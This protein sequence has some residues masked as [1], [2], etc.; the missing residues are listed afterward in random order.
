M[1]MPD[2]PSEPASSPWWQPHVH[3]DR[4]ALLL[5]RNAIKAGLRGWFEVEGF[6][7]VDTAC[8]QVS[9]GN[10]THIHAFAT[11]ILAPTGARDLA[12]LHTSPEFA[13]KKLLA[14]GETQIFT[15]APVF[16]NRDR[17]RLHAPEFMML[18][19]YRAGA[20]FAD[21]LIDCDA[22]IER[23]AAV[24]GVGQFR[25]RGVVCNAEPAERL[26]VCEAFQRDAGIDL[27]AH[28]E[29]GAT[30]DAFT[31]LANAR[32]IRTA[33]DDTW[34][35]IFARVLTEKIEPKL[36]H[37]RP[38]LLTHYPAQEAALARLAPDDP[39]VAERVE[40]YICGV[41]VANGFAELTDADEQRRRFEMAMAERARIY[42]DRYPIDESFLAAL[43]LMPE[44]V[45]CA[46]GFDRLVM[47]TLG[48]PNVASVMWTPVAEFPDPAPSA[49]K[50]T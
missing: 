7:E 14:A 38:T 13:C 44:A 49:G 47:L 10:E 12:Y 17:G 43:E 34:S 11:E 9:P 19:W 45:G 5:A 18:E 26:T 30:R 50:P 33:D 40:L 22:L 35:D 37:P 2:R 32:G 16:R 4:R 27:R 41:E 6:T 36:G 31:E 23:A 28:L 8:L 1:R 29:A 39:N 48:A 15:F 46:L 3:A 21:L 24:A 20:S 25:H 42:G